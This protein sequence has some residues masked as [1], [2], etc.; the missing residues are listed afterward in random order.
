MT[1]K[2]HFFPRKLCLSTR[3]LCLS[4]HGKKADVVGVKMDAK[5]MVWMYQCA[6]CDTTWK[7]NA[8]AV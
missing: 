7:Q 3:K 6:N 8:R 2:R 1:K 4:K 5:D